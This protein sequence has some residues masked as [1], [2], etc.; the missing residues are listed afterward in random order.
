M[1]KESRGVGK[2]NVE[3]H[4]RKSADDSD[5]PNNKGNHRQQQQVGS[6]KKKKTQPLSPR[7]NKKRPSS[8]HRGGDGDEKE[9]EK[10]NNGKRGQ[11]KNRIDSE[12]REQDMENSDLCDVQWDSSEELELFDSAEPLD[13]VTTNPP[14]QV[15][16][17]P[18]T[19]SVND[20]GLSGPVDT[21]MKNS[22]EGRTTWASIGSG[23]HHLENTNAHPS[24]DYTHTSVQ[25]RTWERTQ[26]AHVLYSVASTGTYDAG[27]MNVLTV[28]AMRRTHSA[29][30][31][32]ELKPVVE[33]DH[34]V[35]DST[36][37]VLSSFVWGSGGGILLSEK[38][39][40][41]ESGIMSTSGLWS[42]DINAESSW[43]GLIS[44]EINGRSLYSLSS[45]YAL[46]T[47]L[48]VHDG[49]FTSTQSASGAKFVKREQNPLG[50][51]NVKNGAVPL[52]AQEGTQIPHPLERWN[53]ENQQKSSGHLFPSKVWASSSGIFSDS[54]LSLQPATESRSMFTGNCDDSSPVQPPPS[55]TTDKPS[56]VYI[57]NECSHRDGPDRNREVSKKTRSRGNAFDAAI[58]STQSV[59]SLEEAMQDETKSPLEHQ[60]ELSKELAKSTASASHIERFDGGLQSLREEF[61]N[62]FQTDHDYRTKQQ[63]ELTKMSVGDVSQSVRPNGSAVQ[64]SNISSLTDDLLQSLASEMSDSHQLLS[65]LAQSSA[66]GN[67]L[68]VI[69]SSLKS[70]IAQNKNSSALAESPVSTFPCSEASTALPH[71]QSNSSLFDDPAIVTRIPIPVSSGITD[72]TDVWTHRL[73]SSSATTFSAP[74]YTSTSMSGYPTVNPL[75][76]T[77]IC[78]SQSMATSQLQVVQAEIDTNSQLVSS[79]TAEVTIGA[80]LAMPNT[81]GSSSSSE[82]YSNGLP[83]DDVSTPGSSEVAQF[84]FPS[85]FPSVSDS[86]SNELSHKPDDNDPQISPSDAVFSPSPVQDDVPDDIST[87]PQSL[88]PV[89][90]A[91]A[92]EGY[93]D[94][95][96]VF[97]IEGNKESD[98]RTE[99]KNSPPIKLSTGQSDGYHT[100]ES[101]PSLIVTPSDFKAKSESMM[102]TAEV[103]VASESDLMFLIGCFPHLEPSYL[104]RI[105]QKCSGN[106]E[107]AVSIALVSATVPDRDLFS[108]TTP[109]CADVTYS[110]DETCS[111]ISSA[112]DHLLST[113]AEYP[114]D[115]NVPSL[116][117]LA[118]AHVSVSQSPEGKMG[119]SFSPH[120]EDD[121]ECANDEEIA[122][123]LQEQMNMEEK[124]LSVSE[125]EA[126]GVQNDRGRV[127]SAVCGDDGV[128]SD[129]N[130]EL[131]LTT[132]LA[133]QLQALF[134]PVDQYLPFQGIF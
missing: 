82:L 102:P 6:K 28:D 84:V 113:S 107:D 115:S 31:F 22:T 66:N 70:F 89:N 92:T 131:K 46:L 83:L 57:R 4:K 108:L 86:L 112:S 111:S 132:S 98:Q 130:L 12:K 94:P 68:T 100:L 99:A 110:A 73:E 123:A 3:P 50:V 129:D 61:D 79:N 25:Q 101:D 23:E 9:G 122:R 21:V 69:Q 72:S 67:L 134:G 76:T 75:T 62:P 80:S 105:L 121:S 109:T 48:S 119:V 52:N 40:R 14:I 74:G 77:A 97:T 120:R 37:D 43:P 19:D 104:N 118:L 29:Q 41:V 91:P 26:S 35:L 64:S 11:I 114:E 78:E 65:T 32:Q 87:P 53:Q 106:V 16:I 39:P 103:N 33:E 59:H 27:N 56:E 18:Q 88:T 30:T 8:P 60:S 71:N 10:V 42:S 24:V 17:S 133:R 51:S 38:Q 15:V 55:L 20:Q 126:V 45:E 63:I 1:N 81:V 44:S 34:D 49:A 54:D 36:N 7:L 127:E 5:R 85:A 116:S 93:D 96:I 58:Q 128:H 95:G 124:S 2:D 117:A 47:P 13:Q 90:D 125:S